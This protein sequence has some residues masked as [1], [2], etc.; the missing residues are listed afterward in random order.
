MINIASKYCLAEAFAMMLLLL[1]LA[2]PAYTPHVGNPEITHG[3]LI[4]WFTSGFE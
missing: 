4:G 1:P 2:L 3:H